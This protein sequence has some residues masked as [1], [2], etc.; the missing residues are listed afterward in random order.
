MSA[1][2][3][4][5][6]H[7]VLILRDGTPVTPLSLTI[8]IAEGDLDFT[9]QK[10]ILRVMNRGRIDHKRDGDETEMD[11]KFSFKFE[12][13]NYA[14]GSATGVSPTDALLK[15]GGASA[16]VSTGVSCGPHAVDLVFRVSD[17][18]SATAYEQLVFTGF[19]PE[20]VNFKEGSDANT[21][22]VSGKAQITAPVRTWS[23]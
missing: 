5:L 23:A 13:W 6:R 11:I 3:R 9:I 7:G 2:T 20:S 8:P 18:C 4:N 1:S 16:W 10:N 12:Q 19:V 21:I 17:P 22:S 14:S 15:I